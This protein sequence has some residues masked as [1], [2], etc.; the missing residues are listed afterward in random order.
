MDVAPALGG[1]Q[2]ARGSGGVESFSEM[3]WMLQQW[4][5]PWAVAGVGLLGMVRGPELEEVHDTDE[6]LVNA[7]KAGDHAAYRGL[8]E[9]YQ[10][11]IFTMIYGMV[12][13]REQAQDLTQETFVRGFR[14][15]DSFRQDAKFYTWVYRIAK[16]VSIDYIRRRNRRDERSWEDQV[17]INRD[18]QI[19]ESHRSVLPSKALERK[20]IY[21][22]IMDA[23]EKLS[24]EHRQVLLLRELEGMSY[25]EMAEVCDVPAGTIMSRLYT[26]RR[27][28]RDLL[29][30]EHGIER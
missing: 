13:N 25:T 29:K 6:D 23:V 21:G 3:M 8:V 2:T 4:A 5:L 19:S 14:R 9:K 30:Q 17:E 20:Q 15:L 27:K 28:M 10:E 18:G 16:N 7:V 26:A 24:P 1:R 12:R 22:A 11:R